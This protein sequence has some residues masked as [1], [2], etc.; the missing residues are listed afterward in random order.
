MSKSVEAEIKNFGMGVK[1]ACDY[2]GCS[3]STFYLLLEDAQFPNAYKCGSST[4]VPLGDLMAYRERNKVALSYEN[5][6]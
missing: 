3:R 4:L 5:H 2:L 6:S 1:K